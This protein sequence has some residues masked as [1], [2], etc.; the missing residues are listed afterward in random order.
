MIF[1]LVTWLIDSFAVEFPH[2][3]G[4]MSI[5]FA[6][7]FASAILLGPASA[8]IVILIG[9][10]H[11]SEVIDS[12][13]KQAF[14]FNRAQHVILAVIPGL[15]LY[16]IGPESL[17]LL[18]GLDVILLVGAG[19]GGVFLN[20]LLSALLY[21]IVGR[22]R[23]R[24][25]LDMEFLW[26]FVGYLALIP[27]G[28]GAAIAYHNAG[29]ISAVLL[30]LPFLMAH[31]VF[32]RRA[33]V[34]RVFVDSVY[35]LMWILDMKHGYTHGHSERVSH[36]AGVIAAQLGLSERAV[37]Q[38]R[39]AGL[40]HDI[41]KVAVPRR[42]LNKPERLT[43]EEYEEIKK[44]TTV[45]EEIVKNIPLIGEVPRWIRHHH[46][47]WDGQGFPDQLAGEHIP[48]G[49]RIILAA[50]TLDA[51]TTQRSYREPLSTDQA[52]DEIRKH[53]GRQFDPNVTAALDTVYR[54][55]SSRLVRPRSGEPEIGRRGA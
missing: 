27:L 32:V 2:R 52:M 4:R 26:L 15:I 38:V 14:W 19:L 37:E 28:A 18:R 17:D 42:I 35:S 50:D 46:E 23:F 30:A 25:V 40:L 3:E 6:T 12:R 24:D 9:C 45:G 43:N 54:R 39:Y 34:A 53:A 47:R 20:I 41:G 44:H 21:T 1:S 13:R 10:S 22:R 5:A 55:A 51:M 36:M 7:V 48:L 8:A 49:S 29:P 11:F 31:L 16:A 33:Y